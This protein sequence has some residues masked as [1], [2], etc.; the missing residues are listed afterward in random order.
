MS[1]T[2]PRVKRPVLRYHGGK[3]QLRDW[4]ISQFPPHAVY[5]EPYG[6]AASVLMGK[7]RAKA[8]IYND[9]DSTVVNVFRVLRDPEQALELERLLR[10]TPFARQEFDDC[11]I[12]GGAD[13]PVECARRA[14]IQSFFGYGAGT[15]TRKDKTGFRCQQNDQ[16]YAMPSQDWATYHDAIQSFTER[17]RGVTIE[18]CSALS[19]MQRFDSPGTLH[20]VDPPYVRAVRGRAIRMDYRHEMSDDDH[21]ELAEVLHR[22]QGMVI[23]SGYPSDLYSEL[24]GAGWTQRFRVTRNAQSNKRTECLW[25]RGIDE[26]QL[27][28][29][30]T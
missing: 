15:V 11:Y 25:L 30:N 18:H 2:L 9:L 17:L 1:Q 23:L 6:G 10:L 4:V 19:V 27:F 14:I 13:S 7:P 20:Y 28:N 3:F 5:V 22:L 26:G 29:T 12:G 16:S 24:Y 8:E 21:R